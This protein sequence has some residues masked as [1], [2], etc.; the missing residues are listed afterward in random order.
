MKTLFDDAERG[1]ILQRLGRLQPVSERQWGKMNPAQMMA[2]CAAALETG[3]GDTPRKQA[4]IGKVFAPFVRSSLL[5]DK[6]FSK[7]SPTDPTFIVKDERDFAKEKQRLVSVLGR[8]A[9]GGPAEAAR[10]VHSFLGK[11]KGEEWGVMM[12]KHLDHHLRQFGL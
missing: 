7:N 12:W 5:G 8:F 10:H 4:L 2:H 6:P 11:L 9:E 3:T 1:S